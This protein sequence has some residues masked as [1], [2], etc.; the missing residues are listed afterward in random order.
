[1]CEC[2][3]P[4]VKH[5]IVHKKGVWSSLAFWDTTDKQKDLNM[6]QIAVRYVISDKAWGRGSTNSI[7]LH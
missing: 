1:M 3:V 7:E 6:T 5:L 4:S 2:V